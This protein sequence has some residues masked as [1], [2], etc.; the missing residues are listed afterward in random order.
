MWFPTSEKSLLDGVEVALIHKY[1]NVSSA[2][3]GNS[4]LLSAHHLKGLMLLEI[5]C[6]WRYLF[7][8]SL[9]SPSTPNSSNKESK[10]VLIYHVVVVVMMVLLIVLVV[11]DVFFLVKFLFCLISNYRC[12]FFHFH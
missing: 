4:L 1:F 5:P 12:N 6:I 3:E 11:I 7:N 9:S 2:I 10:I 8:S